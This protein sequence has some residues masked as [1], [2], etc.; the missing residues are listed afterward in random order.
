MITIALKPSPPALS[1]MIFHI[2]FLLDPLLFYKTYRIGYFLQKEKALIV[3]LM[4]TG[5]SVVRHG[6]TWHT[7]STDQVSVIKKQISS[8]WV[9]FLVNYYMPHFSIL[10]RKLSHQ[11]VVAHTFNHRTSLRRQ[12]QTYL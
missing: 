10:K 9:L 5:L 1:S 8:I 12:R 2:F 3:M 11:M 7:Y 4:G 6:K